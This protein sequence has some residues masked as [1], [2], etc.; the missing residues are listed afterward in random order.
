ME[1]T[2]MTDANKLAE[3]KAR[4]LA[5]ACSLRAVLGAKAAA[6]VLTTTAIAITESDGAGG[7]DIDAFSRK[8]LALALTEAPSRIAVEDAAAA[9]VHVASAILIQA[10][11][12]PD[13]AADFLHERAEAIRGDDAP[14]QQRTH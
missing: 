5:T 6:D 12:A 11:V 9:L 4:M 7:G 13:A 14:S 2:A 10:G 3:A 8:A 1:T